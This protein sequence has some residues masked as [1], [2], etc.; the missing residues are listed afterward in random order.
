MRFVRISPYLLFIFL[1]LPKLSCEAQQ[2]AF[3]TIGEKELAHTDVYSLLQ[4]EDGL[5]YAAT[6]DGLYAYKH[7]KFSKFPPPPEQ[8]GSAL[9]NLVSDNDGL[10]FCGNL[11]GQ[12]FKLVDGNLELYAEVPPENVYGNFGFLFDGKNNLIYSSQS[13]LKYSNGSFIP[14][15]SEV[16][17]STGERLRKLQDGRI[18]SG[19]FPDS[20]IA[21][22][23]E[24]EMRWEKI[25]TVK[26]DFPWHEIPTALLSL[27]GDLICFFNN[28]KAWHLG[29]KGWQF[30]RA[31]IPKGTFFQFS[32][33]EIWLLGTSEGAYNLKASKDS[34]LIDPP[35]FENT[36]L[37]TMTEGKDNVLFFGTFG[38]GVIVVPD[39]RAK[40]HDP[41]GG[42]EV[43]QGIVADEKRGA[44]LTTRSGKLFHTTDQGLTL[45]ESPSKG[46]ITRVFL[47]PGMDL[48]LNDEYPGLLYEGKR[49]KD[50]RQNVGALKDMAVVDSSCIL[51]AGAT[52]VA[53]I[54]E[55]LENFPWKKGVGWPELGDFK[56]RSR[57]IAYLGSPD[58]IYIASHLG[59]IRFDEQGRGTEMEHEGG[60]INASDLISYHGQLW[61]AT[62]RNGILIFKDDQVVDKI[63]QEEGLGSNNTKKIIIEGGQLFVLH[64]K[65]IQILD[66]SAG[67]WTTLGAAEG[68]VA[69]AIT[70]FS[71]GQERLWLLADYKPVSIEL[72]KLSSKK[73]SLH[74]FLDS[75]VVSGKKVPVQLDGSAGPVRSFAQSFPHDQ[76]RFSFYIDFREV[77]YMQEVKIRTRLQG[78]EEKWDQK[79]ATEELIEYKSLPAGDFVFEMQAQYRGQDGPLYSY[80][81]TIHPPFWQTWWFFS[82]VG[83]L[84]VVLVFLIFR[85][86]SQR[87][88]RKERQRNELNTSKLTAIQSQMNPHFIFNSLNSIQDLVLQGDEERSYTFITKFANLIRKTLK[89]SAQEFID[90]EQEVELIE[91]Y[92]TLEKQRFKSDLEFEVVHGD[93]E[94][95]QVPPMLI[96]P[97]IENALVHGLLHKEGVGR[98]KI[99]FELDEVLMCTITD[100]GVGRKKAKEIRQRQRMDHE[101]FSVQAIRKRFEI[102]GQHFKEEIGFEYED[103]VEGQE[104]LGT[105]VRLKIPVRRVL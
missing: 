84:I 27:K 30:P 39:R 104:A 93:W 73:P 28:G 44:F 26:K 20:T 1:V 71:L 59:L 23:E 16:N 100:N 83:L 5:L 94:G 55:G 102:L 7:G 37:S 25:T 18:V 75:L 68:I 91:L 66:L 79:G 31:S 34:I 2:P 35:I 19:T 53:R 60:T 86:F 24:G 43:F 76:N 14:L 70:D 58:R 105:R 12:I 92:L 65:G 57:S 101:S 3:F 45:L 22:V 54:G 62:Q 90:L 9:F 98:I 64:D 69:G 6:N 49:Y 46:A 11:S 38:K 95:I 99:E 89:Y 96:Q 29:E 21:W 36:F 13:F 61:C 51:V 77:L 56:Q 72:N 80:V 4:G 50:G 82:V 87:Q 67:N 17:F 88:L 47:A 48:G 74:L 81:F 52:G 97:F 33:D 78:L 103:L 15:L 10:V 32:E 85:A 8:R 40:V 63:D 42:D 41:F